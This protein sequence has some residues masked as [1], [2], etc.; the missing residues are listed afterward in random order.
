MYNQKTGN[1]EAQSPCFLEFF[2]T[3]DHEKTALDRKITRYWA[4][5]KLVRQNTAVQENRV[6]GGIL[7]YTGGLL[8]TRFFETLEKHPCKKKTV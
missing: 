8:L 4:L 1:M 2:L 5:K 6:K 7:A 3:F